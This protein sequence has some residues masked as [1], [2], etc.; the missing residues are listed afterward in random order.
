MNCFGESFSVAGSMFMKIAIFLLIIIIIS[1]G[2]VSAGVNRFDESIRDLA[3]RNNDGALGTAMGGITK[4]GD[5]RSALAIGGFLPDDEARYDAFNT[6]V[7][8]G[9]TVNIMK[10]IIGRRRP[11]GPSDYD[12][13]TTSS[14]YHAMPSGHTATAFALATVIAD[15]YPDYDWLAYTVAGLV[16][17]SRI[18]EDE[19]WATDV[20]AGA[21]VGYGSARLID[22]EIISW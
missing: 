22:F 4:L 20:L 7:T 21:A 18:F 9:I 19:H 2:I 15:H 6:I 16:G 5:G 8:P 17:L 10:A 3:L 13:F 1:S 11:P 14:T 12:H